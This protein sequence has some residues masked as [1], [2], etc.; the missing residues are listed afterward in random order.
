VEPFRHHVFVCT[1][2]KAEGV[3][4]CSAAG[5]FQILNALHRELGSQGLADDVQVS[6]CG[7][8]GICDS[9][10][11]MIVYPEGA[12]YAKLTPNDVPEIVSSHLKAGEK[13]TRLERVPDADMKS[14]ILDHRNKYLA[15][16]KGKDAAG[17]LPDD[18]N[19]MIR[20]FMPSRAILTALELDVFTAVGKG[21]TAQQ[22]AA[23]IQA[24]VRA[25]EMLLNVLVSLKLLEKHDGVYT[26]T[27]VAAR[28]LAEGS[29]D[30]ARAA[31]LHT[32]NLWRR[33]SKLTDA[34][35][36]GT[37]VESG[38][39]N[40]W[41]NSFIAAMDHGARGRA[42]AVAQAVELNG[43]KRMLDLGG[44][45]G[46]YSIA[47]VKAA[48]ALHAEIVDMPEVLPITQEHIRQAGLGDRISTRAGDMLSVPLEPAGYDL[49]LLSAICHMFSPE[50]NRQL[51]NRA[52]AALA[53]HGKLVISDFIL[54]A[55]KTSP[56]FGTLFALNMLVGT[57]AGASYSEPEYEQWLK[58]AGFAA[59]KRIRIPGP[60]NL[61]I[62]TK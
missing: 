33:W 59:S 2:E 34:V 20:G 18:L 19:D 35:R 50:E 43:E 57:R 4:C 42:R 15:M 17:V 60:V 46:A 62:A 36:T 31:Q 24:A 51:L 58:A 32:A 41:V 13:V 11:V 45:S 56:R 16:L 21:G 47:F 38:H 25:I 28:F 7:C 23:K 40:G 39:D 12:W 6:S 53:P 37:A 54:D 22:I 1:Q 9:G 10:P 48:S 52:Y 29:P 8:L 49:V 55:D 26:N 5:S 14:E 27:P 61:M 44:G 3:P 30:S